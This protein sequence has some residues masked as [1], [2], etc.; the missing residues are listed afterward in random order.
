MND[1]RVIRVTSVRSDNPLGRGGAIFYGVAVNEAGSVID[2]RESFVVVVSGQ[3]LGDT[4]VQ[5][6][7]WWRVRGEAIPRSRTI[8]GYH[9]VE[10]QVEADEL[11]LALPSGEHLV[12]LLSESEGFA[13]VGTAKAR[14]LW[15]AF[16]ERLYDILDEGD[17]AALATVRSVS[18]DMAQQIIAAWRLYGD[19]RTLQ[20]LHSRGLSISL[21][22]KVL[23]HFG[24]DTVKAIE[25]DP[26][27]LLSF[28]ANWST[29]DAIAREA[30]GVAEDDPRRLSGAIEEALYRLFADG[31]TVAS[32]QMIVSRLASIIGTSSAD[33][34]WR[35]LA[36]NAISIGQ[37]NGSYLVEQDGQFRQFGAYVMETAVAEAIAGRLLQDEGDGMRLL[38]VARVEGIIAAYEAAESIKLNGEQR[39]AVHAAAAGRMTVVTGGAGV[40]KTTVLKALYRVYDEAG[41]RVFQCALAGRAT[42]RMQ[43]ATGRTARTLAALLKNATEDEF[44]GPA[45]VVVDEASMVDIVSM[46]RLC[47]MLPAHVRLLLTGDQF[48][49][50]PVG[51]GLVLHALV[52]QACVPRVELKVV[53]RY[54]GAIADAANAIREGIWPTLPQDVTAP[55]A[56]VHRVSRSVDENGEVVH[57]IAA[58]IL[59]L[60]GE[61][62]ENTQILAPRKMGPEGV[63]ALNQLC[64]SAM[65]ANAQKL[66][67]WSDEFSCHVDTGFR[68]G[69]PVVC[70]R[71]LWDIGLQNGSLGRLVQIEQQPAA[72]HDD[73]GAEIGRAIGWVVWDDGQRRPVTEALLDYLELAHAL[74]VHK[75]QGSQWPRVIVPITGNRLLDRTLVYTALTRTQTQVI[76]VGDEAAARRAVVAPPRANSRRTGLGAS[77]VCL[78]DASRTTA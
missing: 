23:A 40:G 6:G 39:A 21:G 52:N 69:D 75:A 71:N 70:T 9:I 15:E 12:T 48:Q 53:K 55:I 59:E 11:E 76:L 26:Y 17:A 63:R 49:L 14:R 28:C 36:E 45:V 50:M 57:P 37:Q 73:A 47:S 58:T 30:F 77:L 44:A 60:Y 61:S 38:E 41:V 2:A 1:T 62:P 64:Q 10:Q 3:Q 51:P 22:R 20:W 25:A 7:Q 4:R 13:G 29:A 74:T 68:L 56:F 18:T 16:G 78:L 34:S 33:Y 43:E 67:L 72:L 65:A 32:R 42:K 27:R 46:Y 19:T 35:A 54:G 31:H 5:V 66:T 24:Q 8:S